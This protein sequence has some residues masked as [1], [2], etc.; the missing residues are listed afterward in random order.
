MKEENEVLRR[1]RTEM[2]D[3]LHT[4]TENLFEVSYYFIV[5]LQVLEMD[6][7]ALGVE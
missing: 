3:E 1:A 7:F 5:L 6:T 4:L 2:D